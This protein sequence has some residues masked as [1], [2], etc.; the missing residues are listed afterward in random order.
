MLDFALCLVPVHSTFDRLETPKWERERCALSLLGHRSS[1]VGHR[2]SVNRTLNADRDRPI[3]YVRI[4]SHR[5]IILDAST[6][7]PPSVL[8][9]QS[10]ICLLAETATRL[11]SSADLYPPPALVRQ[12]AAALSP[13]DANGRGKRGTRQDWR[14]DV[15]KASWSLAAGAS[16]KHGTF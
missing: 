8:L 9:S 11:G 13:E 7:D 2:P 6:L 1:I 4:A 3:N 10:S 15:A 5:L 16:I 12:S 14:E